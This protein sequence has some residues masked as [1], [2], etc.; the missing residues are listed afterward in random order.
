MNDFND[1]FQLELT[2]HD[3]I[4]S[5][6]QA[7]NDSMR[8]NKYDCVLYLKRDRVSFHACLVGEIRNENNSSFVI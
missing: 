7:Q 5:T 6:F 4:V 1:N 2:M 8:S 3:F